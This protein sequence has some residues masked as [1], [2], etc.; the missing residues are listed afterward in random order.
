T[1]KR[2]ALEKI[3]QVDEMKNLQD[4]RVTY[5]GKKGSITK[6][7]KGMGK[8]PPEERPLIGETA[9]K[10]RNA[11]SEAIEAKTIELEEIALN[12]QLEE[13]TIDV[14]LPGRKVRVGGPHLLTSIIEEIEDLFIGMGYE[15][16]EGPEV[17]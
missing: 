2:E 16:K 5:L 4:I 11:I 10:V 7:L 3:E 6:V 12:K 17:E 8:L 15:I 13:E 1:L 9:N 14:T